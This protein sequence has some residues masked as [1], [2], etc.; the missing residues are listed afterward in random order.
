MKYS[1]TG[2]LAYRLSFSFPF[3]LKMLFMMT[4]LTLFGGGIGYGQ[5]QGELA[6]DIL[7]NRNSRAAEVFSLKRVR[8]RYDKERIVRSA[9]VPI[10]FKDGILFTYLDSDKSVLAKRND[11]DHLYVSGSFVDWRVKTRFIQNAA[12]IY[13]AFVKINLPAATYTYRFL[14]DN[15]W[16]NDPNQFYTERDRYGRPISAFILT[17]PLADFKV[18]PTRNDRGLYTFYLA[19]NGYTN[20]A[21][22]GT[23][24][25]WNIEKDPMVLKDG[26]WRIK[27]YLRQDEPYYL[28]LVDGKFLLDPLNINVAY[29]SF[30]EE[31]SVVPDKDYFTNLP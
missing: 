28:F 11:H 24:N 7:N 22:L 31:V 20:V 12:G 8:S 27:K 2:F 10:V 25:V 9:D 4:V 14:K 3:V 15:V 29:S 18:S 17:E 23:A 13:T 5:P 1:R 30:Y 21:W 6:T 19:D 16:R 26:Y